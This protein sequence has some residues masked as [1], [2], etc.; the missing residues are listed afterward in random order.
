MNVYAFYGQLHLFLFHRLLKSMKAALI[1]PPGSHLFKV[2]PLGLGYIVAMLKRNGFEVK[3]FDLNVENSSLKEFLSFE[4]P[5]IVGVSCVVA[6]ARQAF[7]I[8]RKLKSLLPQCFIVVGGPYPSVMGERL[9]TKHRE[10]DAAVVGEGES[11]ALELFKRL[12]NEQGLDG[13]NGLIFR[14]KNRVKR[15]PPRKPIEP[16]DSLPFPAR[17]EFLMRLYGENAGVIF[18]SRGCP[19]QCVFCSRPIFGRKWRGHSPEYVLE[20]IEH[21]RRDYGISYLS[22]LDDNFTFDLGRAEKILDGIASKN[23]KLGLYFWNGI[24]VDHVTRELL[25][26][27]KRAGCTA[28]NYGVES[29][30]PDV[31]ANI[32]KGISLDQVEEAIKLTGEFGIKANVFLMVGN[33]GDNVKIVEK[34]KNFIER[35]RVD[36]VHL[37]MATPL[38]GTEFWDWVEENGRWLVYDRE[39]LL[40]WPVDDVEDAYP[41]FE[42]PEFTAEERV[43]AYREIRNLLAKKGLLT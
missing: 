13:I 35:V 14:D 9:L 39:E 5:E 33:P 41:V 6:N 24:R 34:V 3:I 7:E 22:F 2:P 18:T 4:R 40:D 10:I 28:I 15:N 19:Y 8:T 38:L 17:E 26:K 30:D 37:S 42:T 21:M 36:G 32:K 12:Q 43:G 11:T 29:V 1:Q 16:L 23:W 25:L 31:L 27:M 20:E